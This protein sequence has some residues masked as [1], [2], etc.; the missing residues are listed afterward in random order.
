MRVC[1]KKET[2]NTNPSLPPFL[3]SSFLSEAGEWRRVLHLCA[4]MAASA[5]E[6][7]LGSEPTCGKKGEKR[8]P[9]HVLRF[10]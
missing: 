2:I 6:P 7:R 9:F 1:E 8:A 4:D 10:L 3:A 5:L